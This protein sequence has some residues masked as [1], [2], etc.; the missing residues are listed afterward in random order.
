MK[1]RERD[2]CEGIEL[3]WEGGIPTAD[4]SHAIVVCKRKQMLNAA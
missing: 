4:C 3:D 2:C 1:K